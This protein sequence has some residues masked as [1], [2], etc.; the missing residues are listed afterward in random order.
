MI[1]NIFKFNSEFFPFLTSIERTILLN[2]PNFDRT[3]TIAKK[4]T[5]KNPSE[6]LKKKA[7]FSQFDTFFYHA[8]KGE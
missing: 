3:V 6:N 7:E 8:Y 5:R 2:A 1:S 4:E